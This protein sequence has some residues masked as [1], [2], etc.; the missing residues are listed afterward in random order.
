VKSPLAVKIN[1][2]DTLNGA[3]SEESPLTVIS[4]PIADVAES[5]IMILD[6]DQAI[7]FDKDAIKINGKIADGTDFDYEWPLNKDPFNIP[8]LT[9]ATLQGTGLVDWPLTVINAPNATLAAHATTADKIQG[10]ANILQL[11]DTEIEII[12]F[13]GTQPFAFAAPLTQNPFF[14]GITTD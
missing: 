7:Y 1:I 2:T 5:A 8:V 4:A 11:T 9:D 3:G 12:G 14:L 10:G 6:N 13:Q